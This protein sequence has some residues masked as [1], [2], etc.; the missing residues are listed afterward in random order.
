MCRG[1]WQVVAEKE[2]QARLSFL[3]LMASA[4]GKFMPV[5]FLNSP[6]NFVATMT[7][8]QEKQDVLDNERGLT[9]VGP[10][11]IIDDILL[12]ASIDDQFLA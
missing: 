2:V 3:P 5:V 4:V 6:P 10:K 9:R 11:V 7:K 8:M 1:Y 12:N